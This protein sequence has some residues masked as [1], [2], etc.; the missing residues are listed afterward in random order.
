MKNAQIAELLDRYWEGETSLDEERQLKAYFASGDVD[1]RFQV[2][3]V[4]MHAAIADETQQVN[5]FAI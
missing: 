4:R 2:L 5:R 3:D 1:E